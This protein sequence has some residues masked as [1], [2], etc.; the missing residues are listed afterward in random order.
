MSLSTLDLTLA[1][2]KLAAQAPPMLTENNKEPRTQKLLLTIRLLLKL[3][4]FGVE[5]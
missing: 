4:R 1:Q 5:E 3:R 2:S